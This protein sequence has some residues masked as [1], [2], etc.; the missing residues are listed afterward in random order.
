LGELIA[1]ISDVAFE[2]SDNTKDA[3]NIAGQILLE[4]LK[5]AAVRR[6]NVDSHF[7]TSKYV[8]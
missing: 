3:Y 4:I 5:R 1:T 7:S 8:H 6:E 2:Y